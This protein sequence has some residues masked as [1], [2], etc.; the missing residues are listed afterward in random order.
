MEIPAAAAQRQSHLL[1][2]SGLIIAH[3]GT[4]PVTFPL[5]NATAIRSVSLMD[6]AA[7]P[8]I[9]GAGIRLFRHWMEVLPVRSSLA[10]RRP[11]ERGFS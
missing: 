8:S 4:C 10:A 1:E 9:P 2:N 5:P 7:D 3:Y 11:R 6:W